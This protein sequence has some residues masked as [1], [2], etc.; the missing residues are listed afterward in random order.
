M[1]G[2]ARKKRGVYNQISL[3]SAQTQPINRLNLVKN[4]FFLATG[5]PN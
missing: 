1:E 4:K 3:N 2:V 5:S